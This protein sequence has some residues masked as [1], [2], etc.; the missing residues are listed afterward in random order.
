MQERHLKIA[1]VITRLIR[2][3]ADENT[4]LS[5]NAFAERGHDVTLIFGRAFSEEMVRAV[6][7]RVRSV[8]LP[9][10][11]RSI[12]PAADAA[13]LSA[14][15]RCL[16]AVRPDVVHTHTSKAGI[17]GRAA[18]IGLPRTA[19]V[20]G[21]HILPFVNVGM[22][23]RA[24]YLCLERVMAPFTDRY[25]SVSAAM[26]DIAIAHRIGSGPKHD[27]VPS[28]M[29]LERFIKA[30]RQDVTTS[31]AREAAG[32]RFRVLYLANYEPRKQH[33]ALMQALAAG[34]ARFADV[35]LVLAGHGA[36]KEK[37]ARLP[38]K[39]GLADQIVVAGFVQAP[40]SLIASADVCVYC[41]A[42]EG[43]PRAV[44]QYCAA[45]RPVVAFALPGMEAV[46]RDGENGFLCRQDDFAGL[47]DG[48]RKILD[49]PALRSRMSAASARTDLDA[50]GAEHMYHRL[51]RIY[52]DAIC[53]R[54]AA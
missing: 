20:H 37:L 34:G 48:V 45:G 4:L 21:I 15:R 51:R 28:G 9:T 54:C 23:E 47:L 26:R 22:V 7:P 19:V 43:L 42:R 53:A 18:A 13:A 17:L 39:L 1:H 29:D 49:D 52:D 38:E 40:E 36:E 35:E 8:Q 31:N 32:T 27:V 46:V 25:V 12:S 10:L 11:R 6:H 14:L 2:G 24:L 44:V 30:R 5:C 41:S 16:R 3:G 50:W 33:K